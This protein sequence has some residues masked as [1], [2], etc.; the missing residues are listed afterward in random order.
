[1][2]ARTPRILQLTAGIGLV[3]AAVAAAW[4]IVATTAA[5]RLASEAPARALGWRPHQPAA[6]LASGRQA[7]AAGQ[8]A[9][10]TTTLRT[11][12]SVEPLQGSA[13][14]LLDSMAADRNP[15]ASPS[16]Q[17]AALR[18][19]PRDVD[20]RIRLMQSQLASHRFADALQQLSLV[21][22]VDPR[23]GTKVLQALVGLVG[24]PDF[25][26]A[27]VVA[28]QA[29]PPWREN[30]LRAL[31]ANDA[32]NGAGQVLGALRRRGS[33]DDAEFGRWLDS[34]MH[35]GQWGQAY[36]R[37]AG[38]LTLANGVLPAVYNGGFA[39]E[40]SN[41]G[42]DWR[43]TSTPGVLIEFVPD[44]G[45]QGLVAHATFLSRAIAQVNLEQPL[46]LMPGHYR[47]TARMRAE[48]LLSDR[49]L[50]WAVSCADKGKVEQGDGERVEGSF[51]WKQVAMQFE[52]P[53]GCTGQWLRL[54]N[55][56]PHGS[57]Q[58]VSGDLW[59]DDVDIQ[60]MPDGDSPA[61]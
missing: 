4:S 53:A 8:P 51:G 9:E 7:L 10:A 60:R 23:R 56:T 18:R 16:L 50:E 48:R 2:T 47:L 42:F 1:M 37:W 25:A 13:F 57:A 43:V 54:R 3:I 31:L 5:D 24:V 46:L 33:L 59:F 58:T 28:L 38:S 45:A 36:G 49:G 61:H 44:A 26:Q 34:L 17:Q 30:M 27:L 15:R 40:P 22:Q 21:M 12:L 19:A 52:I 6:L 29:N 11:L 32:P 55:P 41:L 35:A 14:A 39:T 20:I